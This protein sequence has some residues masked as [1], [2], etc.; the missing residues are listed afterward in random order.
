MVIPTV[1]VPLNPG[2]C[3]C[4]SLADLAQRA[5]HPLIEPQC[6]TN[7]RCD[8]VRCELDILGTVYF[9]ETVVLPCQNALSLLVEDSSGGV[10]HSS[11]FNRSET[12]SLQIGIFS[13]PTEVVIL[14]HEYSMDI[15]V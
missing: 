9:L 2:D 13:L 1:Y 7:Q 6:S 3:M 15:Q 5:T 12:R 4:D 14:H 11:V 8:G 10:L